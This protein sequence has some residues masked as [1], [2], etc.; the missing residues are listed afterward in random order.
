M[1]DQ[2]PLRWRIRGRFADAA[3]NL[4]EHRLGRLS[5]DD[6]IGDRVGVTLVLIAWLI[7]AALELYPAALLDHVRSLVRCSV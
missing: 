5:S 4:I 1:T 7:D 3:R 2:P 6:A